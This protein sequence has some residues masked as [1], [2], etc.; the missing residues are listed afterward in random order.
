MTL[1][2]IYWKTKSNKDAVSP[3]TESLMIELESMASDGM[4]KVLIDFPVDA[5]NIDFKNDTLSSY[6]I[7][8]ARYYCKKNNT[9]KADKESRLYKTLEQVKEES[10]EIELDYIKILLEDCSGNITKA[11][12]LANVNRKTIYTRIGNYVEVRGVD[13][14]QKWFPECTADDIKKWAYERR[15][16]NI[17]YRKRRKNEKKN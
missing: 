6:A 3:Y 7:G 2:F 14:V 9:D 16:Y 1:E 13:D 8:L 4:L 11:A 17:E 5:D 10:R 15:E 12:L